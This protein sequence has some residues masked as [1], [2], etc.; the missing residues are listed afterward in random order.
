MLGVDGL[1][2][3]LVGKALDPVVDSLARPLTRAV[4]VCL[5][6]SGLILCRLILCSSVDELELDGVPIFTAVAV[7]TTKRMLACL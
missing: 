2:P 5:G 4:L 6:D 1:D 7:A 3:R